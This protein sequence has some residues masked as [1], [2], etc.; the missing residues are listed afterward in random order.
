VSAAPSAPILLAPPV[1]SSESAALDR[2]RRY[3]A[4]LPDSLHRQFKHFVVEEATTAYHVNRA[5]VT[6]LVTDPELA[7]RVR[8]LI[9]ERP[10]A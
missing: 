9:H 7:Q 2:V 10:G 5:L 8:Q 3:T 1:P 6:L 4:E